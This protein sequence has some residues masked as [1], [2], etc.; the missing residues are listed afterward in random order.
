M[1]YELPPHKPRPMS[2]AEQN[3]AET[4][5]F[6]ELHPALIR[7]RN[8]LPEN[9]PWWKFFTRIEGIAASYAR[10]QPLRGVNG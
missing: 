5:V 4:K 1:L 6:R 2:L 10:E 7:A 9:S 3:A 8:S